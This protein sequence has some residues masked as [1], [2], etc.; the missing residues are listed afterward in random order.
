MNL[1]SVKLGQLIKYNFNFIISKNDLVQPIIWTSYHRDNSVIIFLR[2]YLKNNLRPRCWINNPLQCKNLKRKSVRLLINYMI[3]VQTGVNQVGFYLLKISPSTKGQEKLFLISIWQTNVIDLESIKT[4]ILFTLNFLLSTISILIRVAFYTIIERKL[5]SYIQTRKGPN[6]VGLI[7]ILQPFR[8]AIKLFNKNLLS[9]ESIN[10][11]IIYLTPSIAII[12]P[13]II[14]PLIPLNYSPL[15]DIKHTILFIFILSTFS[16]YLILIIGWSANSKYCHLGAIRRVAQIISYEVSFFLIILFISI[17]ANSFSLT[18]IRESQNTLYF[19]W[20]N[21]I[22][23][24]IWLISCL[25]E[26]NRRPFDFAE[27]ESELVSGFNVEY[28]G[29]W[30]ALIFLAEYI[31]ILILRLITTILF[32]KSLNN[33]SLIILILITITLLWIR[34]TIPRFRYDILIKLRWKIFLPISLFLIPLPSAVSF[35]F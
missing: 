33:L 23:F 27:G 22:L 2:S 17:T 30:F 21:R 26:T 16:V 13:I 12:I 15:T 25:A 14:I 19:F 28:I 10:F 24:S 18:Q 32:F 8:D 7:G 6:K 34:G 11:S 9:S 5:L 4:S 1:T 20:G 35:L 29:G 3:W 31:R